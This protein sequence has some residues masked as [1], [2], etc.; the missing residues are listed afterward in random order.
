[1]SALLQQQ[2][3]SF[4]ELLENE[5]NSPI[6]HEFIGG[7]LYSMAGGTPDHADLSVNLSTA[8]HSRLRGKPCRGASPDQRVRTSETATNWYYPDFLIK[9][10]PYR[11]HPRDKNSLLNPHAIFEV[12]SPATKEFD[13]Y[14][15]F[16]EYKLIPEFC[17]YILVSPDQARIEHFR[18]TENGDWIYSVYNRLDQELK[19][20]NFEISV[21]LREIYEDIEVGIQGV[22]PFDEDE[23]EKINLEI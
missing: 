20:E 13:R 10:P 3:L 5:E 19:L 12:S 8:V 16:D 14:A 7:R 1:M 23:I 9:C 6:R 2:H 17:D 11:F 15:K 18:K 22:L 4:E 21:P